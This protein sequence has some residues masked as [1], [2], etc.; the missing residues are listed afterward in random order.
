MKHLIYWLSVLIP[1]FLFQEASSQ[2]IVSGS[3]F[4]AEDKEPM[5]GATVILRVEDSKAI[6]AYG[7]SNSKGRFEI[8]FK[9][10]QSNFL[11]EVTYLGYNKWIQQ[12][13]KPTQNLNISL[14]LSPESLNE[15]VLESSAIEQRNDTISY[16]INQLKKSSDQVIS[17][18][19]RRLPGIEIKPT[20]EIFYQGRPINKYY[21]EGLDLLEGRYNLAND[22]LSV[23]SVSK[24]E[25]LENHQPIRILTDVEV[26]NRAAINIKLKNN[27][28]ASGAA[29][30]ALGWNNKALWEVNATPI[31]FSKNKQFLGSYQTNNTGDNLLYQNRD[32]F[33]NTDLKN[34]INLSIPTTPPFDKELWLD[35]TSHLGSLN[36]LSRNKKKIDKKWTLSYSDE[37]HILKGTTKTDYF[38]VTDSVE[39][40]EN[41][42]SN[43]KN[44][45]LQGSY[46]IEK[47]TDKSYFKHELWASLFWK[48]NQSD[49]VRESVINELLDDNSY[50]I[51]QRLTKLVPIGQYILDLK[52]TNYLT[53]QD[54]N[55]EIR[56]AQFLEQLQTLDSS[57]TRQT[58][59][60]RTFKTSNSI[61]I[62]R[63]FGFLKFSSKFGYDYLN[64]RF[65]SVLNQNE[66]GLILNNDIDFK[67]SSLYLEPTF[68]FKNEYIEGRFSFPVRRR[69]L[70]FDLITEN[71]LLQE[72]FYNFEPNAWLKF[73]LNN[74]WNSTL[75]FS[76]DNKFGSAASIYPNFIV[77]NY[78]NIQRYEGLIPRIL[79]T[80]YGLRL[81]YRNTLKGLFARASYT[82]RLRENNL[83]YSTSIDNNGFLEI[84]AIPE[85]N[86]IVDENLSLNVGKRISSLNTVLNLGGSYMQNTSDRIL[87]E[88]PTTVDNG[89]FNYTISIDTDISRLLSLYLK[90]DFRTIKAK[91][92]A[93]SVAEINQQKYNSTL[94]FNIN[95]NSYFNL[96]TVFFR[97]KPSPE[98][99][100]QDTHFVNFEYFYKLKKKKIDFFMKWQNILNNSNY[101]SSGFAENFSTVS[102]FEIRP[103]QLL[104]GV[105]LSL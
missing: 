78:R 48:D 101:I 43:H 6:L 91:V 58:I 19:I 70:Q 28:T 46:I 88:S 59:E 32:F 99:L 11:L 50:A 9:E 45:N 21:I 60:N 1:F 98:L 12:L 102:T 94:V 35:N 33:S 27:V 4:S 104:F 17:D 3:V 93:S 73:K 68:N 20:G 69:F 55:Y 41:I 90:G 83:L 23:G 22:N 89:I 29:T 15:I 86:E 95:Q 54:L 36:Y 10:P 51:S 71:E 37:N 77:T 16:N 13:E 42:S 49:I 105:R 34:P 67:N 56:P 39:V 24:V 52:T 2:S 63:D 96:S 82:H 92:D 65:S 44:K 53:N 25:I 5:V 66:N 97:V 80:E 64:E 75:S 8:R 18:V 62:R 14:E 84:I 57:L 87:N 79:T 103:T 61:G 72:D 47:N 85:V 38:L 30:G 7:I 31:L 74:F 76:V 81:E 40:R 100:F 26:S